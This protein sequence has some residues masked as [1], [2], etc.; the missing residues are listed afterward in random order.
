MFMYTQ[1][2]YNIKI[3][4]IRY[5]KPPSVK[6]VQNLYIRA[7]LKN[8]DQFGVIRETGDVVHKCTFCTELLHHLSHEYGC[9]A[10]VAYSFQQFTY[11]LT[12]YWQLWMFQREGRVFIPRFYV[13]HCCRTD[14]VVD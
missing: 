5:I 3:I 6:I 7:V 2:I 12:C 10:A 11:A 8:I 14:D 4:M 9:D 13:V 1:C